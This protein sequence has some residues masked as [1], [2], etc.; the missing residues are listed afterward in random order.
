MT[1][2]AA[3]PSALPAEG[4]AGPIHAEEADLEQFTRGRNPVWIVTAV[5]IMLASMLRSCLGG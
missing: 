3:P 2:G 4:P 5:L 1:A